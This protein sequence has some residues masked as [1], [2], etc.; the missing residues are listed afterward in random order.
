MQESNDPGQNDADEK[1]AD[2]TLQGLKEMGAFG[3]QVCNLHFI[4][5]MPIYMYMYIHLSMYKLISNVHTMQHTSV[6]YYT[7]KV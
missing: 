7:L 2:D 4:T 1:V 3:L 6:N 5:A